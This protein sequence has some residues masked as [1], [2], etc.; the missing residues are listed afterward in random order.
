MVQVF[1]SGEVA[2]RGSRS[3]INNNS[4]VVKS[5]A[6][7]H[8]GLP[9]LGSGDLG[10]PLRQGVPPEYS[11]AARGEGFALQTRSLGRISKEGVFGYLFDANPL[12]ESVYLVNC[13]EVFCKPT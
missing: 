13:T 4:E 2:E 7:A 8:M 1:V 12:R 9:H 10:S 3:E 11:V 6:S 5:L